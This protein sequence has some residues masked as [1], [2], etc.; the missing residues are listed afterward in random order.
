MVFALVTL[1]AQS[2]TKE[3]Y[4]ARSFVA[5]LYLSP[6]SILNNGPL[7]YFSGFGA[8]YHFAYF[9][10]PGIDSRWVWKSKLDHTFASREPVTCYILG[11]LKTGSNH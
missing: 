2:C 10:A 6:K 8:S 1:I 11:A 4:A 3:R 7:G 5:R 9:G